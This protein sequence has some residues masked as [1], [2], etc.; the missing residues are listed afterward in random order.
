MR[1]AFDPQRC[2]H[3]S[4]K[5]RPISS[6]VKASQAR[7]RRRARKRAYR[8]QRPSG[9]AG[10]PVVR[11]PRSPLATIQSVSAK[12]QRAA[13]V[14]EL[15]AARRAGGV[16]PRTGDEVSLARAR[17]QV[18]RTKM[19]LGERG[20]V[21]W[22]DGSPD[23]NRRLVVN[24]FLCKLVERAGRRHVIRGPLPDLPAGIFA[25][26]DTSNDS[27]STPHLGSSVLAAPHDSL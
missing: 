9:H 10:R 27:L 21:W 22:Q 24:T 2:P 3:S 13:S 16:A 1:V 17:A 26:Q 4:V 18:D 14:D 6:L 20:P 8:D 12:Q 7:P 15:M 25:E 23:L 5:F 19:A 11:R